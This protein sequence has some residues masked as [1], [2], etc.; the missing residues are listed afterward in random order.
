MAPR[1]AVI[2]DGLPSLGFTINEKSECWADNV[3]E[4]YEEA[5]ARQWASAR[6]IPWAEL[7]PLPHDLE[8]AMC[9]LCTFLTEVQVIAAHAPARWMGQMKHHLFR[10]KMVLP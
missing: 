2:P 1:G 7:K 3:S 10:A 9:Q 4:L 5:V 6:D 8:R